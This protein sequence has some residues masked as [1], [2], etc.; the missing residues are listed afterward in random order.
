M[1]TIDRRRFLGIA[2]AFAG[3]ALLARPAQATVVWRGQALGAPTELILNHPDPA[4]ARILLGQVV[5]ELARLER[6]FTLYRDDSDLVA[7][8][9]KGVQGSCVFDRDRL[10]EDVVNDDLS[11]RRQLY[12]AF[13]R[14]AGIEA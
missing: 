10:A 11:T 7:L 9:R 14:H 1:P 2:A 8:N 13:Q 12:L 3:A 6:I 5:A 4:R